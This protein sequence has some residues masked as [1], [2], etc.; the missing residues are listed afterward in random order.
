[1]AVIGRILPSVVV[2]PWT[3][4]VSKVCSLFFLA[5]VAADSALFG[6]SSLKLALHFSFARAHSRAWRWVG[7]REGVCCLARGGMYRGG[8]RME[9]VLVPPSEIGASNT[10]NYSYGTNI[11]ICLIKALLFFLRILFLS[12]VTNIRRVRHNKTGS[13]HSCRWVKLLLF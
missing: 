9:R 3:T 13:N 6:L 5:L 1:M 11:K 7:K 12:W 8:W 4:L 10:S 2:S